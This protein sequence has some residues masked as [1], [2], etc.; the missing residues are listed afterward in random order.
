M[1]NPRQIKF[2]VN[3]I[4]WNKKKTMIQSKF[5]NLIKNKKK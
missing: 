1:K 2:K 3:L 5:T 4:F